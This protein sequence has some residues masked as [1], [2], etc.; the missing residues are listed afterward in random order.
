M[1][2]CKVPGCNSGGPTTR[3]NVHKNV[4]RHIFP[5]S[6]KLRQLWL[7]KINLPT[8]TDIKEKDFV[9]DLHFIE[10]DYVPETLNITKRG[11]LKKKKSLKEGAYPSLYINEKAPMQFDNIKSGFLIVYLVFFRTFI[12]YQKFCFQQF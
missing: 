1:P 10:T 4:Q 11:K 9:C 6:L 12:F 2:C 5:L 8:S 3:I 7:T